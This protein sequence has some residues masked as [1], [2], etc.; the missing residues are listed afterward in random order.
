MLAETTKKLREFFADKKAELH[1]NAG[2]AA[3]KDGALLWLI[4]NTGNGWGICITVG[5][6]TP[7]GSELERREGKADVTLRLYI[8]MVA[9]N[10]A[11]ADVR[12]E[13]LQAAW[14]LVWGYMARIRWGWATDGGR[15]GE[16][17]FMPADGYLDGPRPMLPGPGVFSRERLKDTKTGMEKE[18]L[19]GT[20][21]WT[22]A[23]S[24]PVLGPALPDGVEDTNLYLS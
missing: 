24:L 13:Q 16:R 8:G 17:I 2:R 21:E 14:M 19:L 6:V 10:P 11:D 20:Q 18:L 22:L 3:D 15:P 1:C 7:V 4:A 23:V 12:G 5:N 9:G